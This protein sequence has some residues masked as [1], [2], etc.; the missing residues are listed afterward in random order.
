VKTLDRLVGKI[1]R[2]VVI[3]PFNREIREE[4]V[5]PRLFV[6]GPVAGGCLEE[7]VFQISR[8]AH[9]YIHRDAGC[10]DARAHSFLFR[11]Q[12]IFSNYGLVT[13]GRRGI[14]R[15]SRMSVEEVGLLV[16]FLVA[17]ADGLSLS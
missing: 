8:S 15:P 11:E 6:I 1:M 9:L 13:G 14:A 16:R 7:C 5:N 3:D 4:D 2:V 17:S 10:P 12:N